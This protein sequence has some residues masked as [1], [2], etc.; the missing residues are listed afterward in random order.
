MPP[1][2]QP[3]FERFFNHA[4]LG[5]LLDAYAAARPRLVEKFSIGKSQEGRDI[6]L[7]ALT[8]YDTG[9]HA[10]KPA[11]WVDGNIHAAELLASTACLYYLHQLLNGYGSDAAITRLLDTRTI[12]LVPRLCPDGAEL[13]LAERPRHVRSGTRR[14][15]YDEAPVDGLTPEDIDGDGRILSMRIKDANGGWR[16]HPDDP[17]V[18]IPRAPGEFGGTY[19]RVMPEGFVQGFDGIQVRVNKDVEGLDLN[20]NFPSEWRQ[21]F[22]QVGAGPYPT[23][24]PE[25]RAVVDFAVKHPNIGAAISYHTHSGVILRCCGTRSDDDMIPED[26]WSIKR[27]SE[28]GT[29]HTGYPAISTWHDFKYHPKEVI[30][31]TQQW[32]YEHLGALFWVVELWS[33]NKAAGITDYKWIDWYR[34]HPAEHDLK[35]IRWSDS[36]GPDT[37]FV[38]WKPFQHPQLGEVEIGGWDLMNFWRNPPPQLREQE[39]R[40]FPLWMNQLA[41]SLPRLELLQARA[42]ALGEDT[43][44]VRL[45]VCNSGFLPSHV[46]Q[47]AL[48]REVVRG[49]VFEIQLPQGDPHIELISGKPRVVG[50]QLEGH[51]PKSSPHHFVPSK[52]VTADRAVTEWLVRAPRGTRLLLTARH[53]RA[54]VVRT[55][56]VLD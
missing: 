45:A 52:E 38:N 16:Q 17:R 15:P 44:R 31:G 18:L 1:L 6:W 50:P 12:Y 26:L 21:E 13:A 32:F 49:V 37:A 53:E 56:L 43:W 20:R 42:Q 23:S 24:E 54:G 2:P 51:A 29:Q 8:N 22:E 10:D 25:V 27:F 36:L 30:T 28:L 34:E 40:Q 3:R 9:A 19:Y 41:L 55:E 7:L 4:E 39:V 14:Y 48:Q 46:T 33:P 47:Q 11:L 5:E 35:L